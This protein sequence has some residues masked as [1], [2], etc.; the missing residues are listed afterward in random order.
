MAIG[1]MIFYSKE[2]N[3]NTEFRFILP[4]G[5]YPVEKNQHYYERPAKAL[6]LLHGHGNGNEEWITSSSIREVSAR[7][8]IAVFMP[9]G[10]NSFYL[11]QKEAK[12]NYADYVG[13]EL[14]EYTRKTFHLSEKREDTFVG[15]ISMGGFGA[16]HT[17]LMFPETFSKIMALSSA[18][19]LYNIA[20]KKEDFNDKFGFGEWEYYTSIFGDLEHILEND[21][22]PEYLADQIIKSRGQVPGIYMAC[23]TEDFLLETNRRFA[24]FLRQNQIPAQYYENEGDHNFRFWNPHLEK[25]VRW[26]AESGGE[27]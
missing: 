26:M 23:G 7:Y 2:M 3:R 5:P 4:E 17:G 10:E 18:L 9:S 14:V 21:T 11:N 22:N 19:I 25:A 16:L 20:G 8:N 15:G 12:K 13:K 27:E 1:E 24:K 6:Y